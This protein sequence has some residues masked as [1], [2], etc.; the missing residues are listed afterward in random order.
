MINSKYTIRERNEAVILQT[1]IEHQPI[2]RAELATVTRLNKAS[3]SSI[4]KKLIEEEL[5]IETGIGDS[6]NVGGRKPIMLMFNPKAALVIGIDVG[7]NYLNGKLTYLD[8]ETITSFEEKNIKINQQTIKTELANCIEQLLLN[9]PTTYHGIVGLT[10]AIHGVV[11]NEEIIYTPNY[12]LDQGSMANI[13]EE[14][15]DCP[16]FIENEANLAALG[17]YA[18]TSDS[19]NLICISIH[20]G[21]GAGIV[22]NG[23]LQTGPHGRAGEIGH[24]VLFPDGKPCPCGNKGCLEQYASH[25]TLYEEIKQATANATMNSDLVTQLYQEHH[26]DVIVALK[27]NSHY[28]SIGVNNLIS[29][30]DPEVIVI[31][32]SVYQKNPAMLEWLIND[33]NTLQRS[34]LE[35][36]NSPLQNNATLQGATIKAVQQFLNISH[37]K[38][39]K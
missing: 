25:V 32:S 15:V 38:F 36:I 13:L 3:V 7:T 14:L 23:V 1:I 16:V 37:L 27:N 8:A 35:I 20:D 11:L 12:D 9:V 24:S 26:P 22:E 28:L 6:S 5:I 33:L 21:I 10:A 30:Y 31:N 29:V 34:E 18:F 39:I 4:T 19:R 2:S 17:E